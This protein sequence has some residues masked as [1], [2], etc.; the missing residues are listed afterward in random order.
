MKTQDGTS[1]QKRSN[2]TIATILQ[3]YL[4]GYYRWLKVP[5]S[6]WQREDARLEVEIRAAHKR[7]RQTCGP[8]RLR[9]DLAASGIEVGVHRV[10]RIRR[11]LGLR[12]QQTK[13]YKETTNST[14]KLP[15]APN[16]LN[17][18]FKANAPSQIWLSDIPYI[19]TRKLA[20]SSM[21]LYL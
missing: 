11:K 6:V 16:L 1:H 19:V 14:H 4:S 20:V 7:T 17:Q 21:R 8:E 18:K 10:K 13:K 3:V 5:I 9:E 15:V 2:N 12:C